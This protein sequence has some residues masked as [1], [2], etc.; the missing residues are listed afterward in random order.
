MT[1]ASQGIATEPITALIGW[2]P[3]H[4]Q[5]LGW[6]LPTLLA[7]VAGLLLDLATRRKAVVAA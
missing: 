6:A 1:L 4:A 7:L 3:G 2:A 5:E